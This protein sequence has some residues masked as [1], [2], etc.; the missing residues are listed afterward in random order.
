MPVN[1]GNTCILTIHIIGDHIQKKTHKKPKQL[2]KQKKELKAASV[3]PYLFSV[4]LIFIFPF[5]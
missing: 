3:L 4:S 2:V 1:T 5:L